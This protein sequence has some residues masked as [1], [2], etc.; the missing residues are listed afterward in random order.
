MNKLAYL[1]TLPAGAADELTSSTVAARLED[2]NKVID[3]I[4]LQSAIYDHFQSIISAATAKKSRGG[5][6]SSS[7]DVD[8]TSSSLADRVR[9][10]TK[11]CY[12]HLDKKPGFK[13]IANKCV[14]VVLKR[15]TLA[16]ADMVELLTFC[17][18]GDRVDWFDNALALLIR[19][20]AELSPSQFNACLATIWRRAW[21]N[22]E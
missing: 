5:G 10:V 3:M 12:N 9:F 15:Q 14:E 6:A 1:A 22:A 7:S 8:V 21:L 2:Y 11:K 4:N 18:P 19:L 20:K 13:L 17:G 16:I